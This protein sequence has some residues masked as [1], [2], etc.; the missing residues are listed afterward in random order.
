MLTLNQMHVNSKWIKYL[1]T[2]DKTL[3]KKC[4]KSFTTSD[5]T[6]I[7]WTPQKNRQLKRTQ[8]NWTT[9]KLKSI[10]CQRVQQWNCNPRDGEKIAN[11]IKLS[12]LHRELWQLNKEKLTFKM[13]KGSEK[14]F[15]QRRY[16][17]PPKEY[18]YSVL[19]IIREIQ[20]KTTI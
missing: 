6:I 8:I 2:R 16:P 15:L 17:K 7:S 3:I 19:L 1:N 14:T 4:K 10:M 11:L 20:I 9:L 5:L 13:G 18:K 12:R